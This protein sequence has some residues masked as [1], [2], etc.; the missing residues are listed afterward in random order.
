MGVAIEVLFRGDPRI[1]QLA[2]GFAAEWP[3]WAATLS[4]DALEAGFESGAADSLPRILVADAGGRAVGTIAL[5]AW[6]GDEP[7]PEMYWVRGLWVAPAW[8]GRGIDRLLGARV[9][10]EARRLGC[11]TL[12]A[13]TTSIEP[14]LARRGWAVFRRLEHDGRP[15]AW[16]AKSL[17]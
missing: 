2:D 9:E 10:A 16:L 7:M 15:M 11:E 14:L 3:G 5:R 8:R 6:F 17:A 12:H 4:R 1:A 13:A